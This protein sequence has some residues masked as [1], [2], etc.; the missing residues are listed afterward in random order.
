MIRSQALTVRV[1]RFSNDSEWH[2][3]L[4]QC[5]LDWKGY[6]WRLIKADYQKRTMVMVRGKKL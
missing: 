1:F 4:W 5:G 6:R 3:T 2:T